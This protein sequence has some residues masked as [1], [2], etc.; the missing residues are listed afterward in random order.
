MGSS[1]LVRGLLSLTV[2]FIIIILHNFKVFKVSKVIAWNTMKT[3][4]IEA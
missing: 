4:A 3:Y 2:I 1:V